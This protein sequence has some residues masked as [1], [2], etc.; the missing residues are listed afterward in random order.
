MNPYAVVAVWM[1][2]A[3]VAA[4][5]SIRAGVAVALVEILVGGFAG[6]LPG[7]SSVVQQTDFTTFLAA[8]GSVVLT[9]LA[10]AEIDPL[11][12]RHNW[13]AS[14]SIGGV[15]FLLPF[16]GALAVCFFVLHWDIQAAEIGG[17]ALSTT[18][19]AVVY[20]VMVETGLN[21]QEIGKLVLAACFVT[22]LGTVLALSRRSSSSCSS[23][24]PSAG[25][26]QPPGARPCCRPTWSG[27]SAPG[28]SSA[29]GCSW[30][31]CGQPPSRCSPRSSFSGRYS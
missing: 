27:L 8:F 26:P 21:R 2:L 20:A 9:F 17:V 23:S 1:A 31:G 6:N 13:K 29:I 16:L 12:L 14:L 25:W 5:I 11:S 15:S 4:L 3:L 7:V 18:S 19:V 10:G 24:S 30:I 28:S 22:D